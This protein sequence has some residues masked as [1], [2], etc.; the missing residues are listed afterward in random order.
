MILLEF[1]F[2]CLFDVI[3]SKLYVNIVVFEVILDVLMVV[4]EEKSDYCIFKFWIEY[5]FGVFVVIILSCSLFGVM[6]Y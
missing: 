5:Q 2:V 4:F 1:E 6:V 3:N